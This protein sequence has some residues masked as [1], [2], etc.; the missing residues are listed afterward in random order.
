MGTFCMDMSSYETGHDEAMTP[1]YDDE[2]LCAGWIPALALHQA[3][4]QDCE[5]R[6]AMPVD[7]MVADT[8]LF[9]R[10]MYACQ[11]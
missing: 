9:L 2:V 1:D 4:S 7:L 10:R 11:R 8:D 6:P 3:R 5:N